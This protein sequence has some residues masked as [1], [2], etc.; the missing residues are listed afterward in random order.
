MMT[1]RTPRSGLRSRA[2]DGQLLE[3]VAG[4]P[5]PLAQ[6]GRVVEQNR[7]PSCF[8]AAATGVACDARFGAGQVCVLRQAIG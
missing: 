8:D 5:S 6:A 3:R 4:G 2:R 1:K 7:R